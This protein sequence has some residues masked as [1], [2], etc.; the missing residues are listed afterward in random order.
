MTT[1]NRKILLAVLLAL[2]AALVA[3]R[4]ATADER[5]VRLVFAEM[6]SIAG[7]DGAG[8]NPVVAAF[9]AARLR[10]IAAPRIVIAAPEWR[11]APWS[12]SRDDA[13]REFFSAKAMASRV[14]LRFDSVRIR[15][16]HRGHATATAAATLSGEFPGVSG[17][18][19]ESR[20]VSLSL[21]RDPG[22]RAWLVQ[23]VAVGANAP[24]GKAQKP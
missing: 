7:K 6:E 11:G 10:R 22:S 3:W 9:D 17:A 1:K 24:K 19:R 8:E 2:L 12:V 23:R 21:T 5:R 14:S 20:N 13:V 16:P 15:F 18:L 4:V